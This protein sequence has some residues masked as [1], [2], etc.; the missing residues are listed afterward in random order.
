MRE[1]A[2]WRK[3]N[4]NETGHGRGVVRYKLP[5]HDPT[6]EWRKEAELCRDIQQRA[7]I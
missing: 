2:V 4:G 1:R 7:L 3:R 5:K 6:S